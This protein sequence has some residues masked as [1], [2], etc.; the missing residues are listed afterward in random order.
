[1]KTPELFTIGVAAVTQIYMAEIQRRQPT[2]PYLLGGWS[3]GGVL[4]FEMTRQ[5]VQ[6]G[7]KVD[8]LLLIDSPCPVGLEALPSSFHRFCN[9]IGLLGKGNSPKIPS[10]LLPHF[11][12]TVRE[13]TSYSESLDSMLDTIDTSKMPATTAI[14][15]RDGIVA[16]ETDPKP[17]WDPNVRMPNSMRWL[18]ENR[19]HR[20]GTNGWE[21]LVGKNIK[22][23]S[24][25]VNHFTMM[26]APIVSQIL[27]FSVYSWNNDIADS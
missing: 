20:L 3:A 17:D 10:W 9:S 27:A 15:A 12:A 11:V 19:T 8:K 2:G 13:I 25:P 7:E 26:R 4:A 1:M 5:L 14:W 21:Q 18:V 23:V 16:R 24:T 6:K 22:C